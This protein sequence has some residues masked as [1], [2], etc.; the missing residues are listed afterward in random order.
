MKKHNPHTPILIREA[1][2]FE[3]TL[4]ARY[5]MLPSETVECS[6]LEQETAWLMWNRRLRKGD[7]GSA[8]RSG[9]QVDR[10]EGH[11]ARAEVDCIEEAWKGQSRVSGEKD[12]KQQRQI[13]ARRVHAY[14]KQCTCSS[15][16]VVYEPLKPSTRHKRRPRIIA[17]AHTV[18]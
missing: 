1:S 9:R 3:P 8:E 17:K 13:R 16:N 18:F 6:E 5:S 2:G 12:S 14:H 11:R 4:F 7:K 10:A 15:S